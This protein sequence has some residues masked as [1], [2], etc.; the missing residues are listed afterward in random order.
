MCCASRQKQNGM[1][2]RMTVDGKQESNVEI[3]ELLG[4]ISLLWLFI[5]IIIWCA[6]IF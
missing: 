1:G 5:I 4:T 3:R 2:N 6:F